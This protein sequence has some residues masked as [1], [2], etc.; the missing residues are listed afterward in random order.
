MSHA[1][2]EGYAGLQRDLSTSAIVSTDR[3]ALLAARARK[4]AILADKNR[5]IELETRLTT[6]EELITKMIGETNGKSTIVR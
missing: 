4:A 2:V 6:L 5:I 3:E 1:T